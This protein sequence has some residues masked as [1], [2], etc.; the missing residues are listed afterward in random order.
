[1][2]LPNHWRAPL[3]ARGPRTA[4]AIAVPLTLLTLFASPGTARA[5]T[6]PT[7]DVPLTVSADVLP[8]VQINGVVWDQVIVGNTAYVTGEFSSARPARAAPGKNETPRANILAFD[9]TTGV[10]KSSW[11]PSLNAQGLAIAAS[12]DGKR[13]I[14]AGD[15]T[16][17][18]GTARSRIAELDADTGALVTS[19][20]PSFN[21]RVRTLT[22]S[23]GTVYVGGIFTTVSGRPRT[24]LAALSVTNGAVLDWAPTANAEVLTMTAPAGTDKLVVGGR[25]STLNGASAIGMGAVDRRSGAT[26]PWQANATIRNSGTGAAITSL[27]S[28]GKQVYGTGYN[29]RGSGNLEGHFA[30]SSATGKIVWINDCKGDSYDAVPLSGVLYVASHAHDCGMVQGNPEVSPRTYQWATATTT[31]AAADGRVNAYVPPG[32]PGFKGWR[33][34]ELLHW[35]PTLA[36][37]S[38]TGQNQAAWTTTGN[39]RYLLLG[40]EFPKI[41][42]VAQQGLARFAVKAVAPNQTRPQGY[43][44]LDLS[45]RQTGRSGVR[46]TFTTAWD[47]DNRRLTYE[48]LRGDKLSTAEVVASTSTDSA[49]WDRPRQSLTDTDAPSGSTASYRLRVKDPFGNNFISPTVTVRVR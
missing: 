8:T 7:T 30:A 36:A 34:S 47:R 44:D 19:F 9:I 22:V 16:A 33:A 6:A 46:A 20:S 39:D 28:D 11:R 17:V 43:S 3:R 21:A 35:L 32:Y 27:S 23:G 12:D 26:L 25:F 37:G 1:M 29:Y 24:R 14:V 13:I 10:L 49:W 42:G 15:F 45:V 38:Y 41:N 2:P 4:A 5:D 40:G 31:A 48:L 18:N